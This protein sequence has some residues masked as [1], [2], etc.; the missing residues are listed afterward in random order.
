MVFSDYKFLSE[1]SLCIDY[2]YKF[3][4]ECSLTMNTSDLLPGMNDLLAASSTNF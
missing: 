2:R 3:L 4:S 1:C